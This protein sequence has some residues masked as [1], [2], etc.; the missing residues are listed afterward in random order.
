M[1]RPTYQPSNTDRATA[2]AMAA[3]GINH[4]TIARCIGDA[5]IDEKTLR[6]HFRRELDTSADKSNALVATQVFKAAQRGEAWACCFWL[7]CRAGWKERS[8][9]EMEKPEEGRYNSF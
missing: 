8:V 7:K 3:A 6:K 5:G 9:V 2:E 4:A 1:A